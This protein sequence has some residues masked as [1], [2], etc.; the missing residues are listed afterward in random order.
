MHDLTHGDARLLA[1]PGVQGTLTDPAAMSGSTLQQYWTGVLRE[2][3]FTNWSNIMGAAVPLVP[4][5]S[6]YAHW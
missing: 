1:G 5:S 2:P 4:G 3:G 6:P